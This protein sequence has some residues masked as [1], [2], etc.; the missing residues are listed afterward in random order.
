MPRSRSPPRRRRTRSHSRHRNRESYRHQDHDRDREYRIRDDR[1]RAHSGD[2]S[3]SRD[4]HSRDR[5]RSRDRKPTKAAEGGNYS[6]P[7]QDAPSTRG[8][9]KDARSSSK[10]LTRTSS[11]ANPTPD[12]PPAE[13]EKP[14]FSTTGALAAAANTVNNVVLKYHEPADSRLAPP[15][16]GWRLFVFKDGNIVDTVELNSRSCWLL[17]RDRAVADLPIDHPSCSK[18]HAVLQFRHVVK[19]DEF[20]GKQAKVR[21]YVIDLESAN[22]TTLNGDEIEGG[23]YVECREG[24]LLKFGLSTREYVIMLDRG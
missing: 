24:D 1:A 18:Q 6:P 5:D 19:T 22:G 3:R 14:N 7:P 8:T 20:G 23:R 9:A 11:S 4:R 13:K 17:G 21:L 15:S 12:A 10:E 2:R 16:P